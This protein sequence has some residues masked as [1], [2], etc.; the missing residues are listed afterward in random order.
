MI[1]SKNEDKKIEAT[2]NAIENLNKIDAPHDMHTE[3]LRKIQHNGSKFSTSI[4]LKYAAVGLLLIVNIISYLK[5]N[6]QTV[7]QKNNEQEYQVSDLIAD[8]GLNTYEYEN[9]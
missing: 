8:Y 3:V 6:N 2:F 4:F 7:L 9:Y 1:E 5:Y